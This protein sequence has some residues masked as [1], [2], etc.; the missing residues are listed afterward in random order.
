DERLAAV[1]G[2]H[3]P[4]QPPPLLAD[5][6]VPQLAREVLHPLSVAPRG[7]L[8]FRRKCALFWTDLIGQLE[9]IEIAELTRRDQRD[10]DAA[11]PRAPGPPGAVHVHL[12]GLRERVVDDVREVADV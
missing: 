7:L 12:G 10:G 2:P 1:R 4:R 6:A 8:L 3:A 5:R 9:V 11:L